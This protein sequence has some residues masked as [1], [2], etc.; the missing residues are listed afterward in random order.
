MTS[1]KG[2]KVISISLEHESTMEIPVINR[3]L[4]GDK[5]FSG[6]TERKKKR[7]SKPHLRA[8]EWSPASETADTHVQIHPQAPREIRA[9]RDVTPMLPR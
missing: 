3:L 2:L 4:T 5:E 8:F 7:Q 9:R 6:L 1:A